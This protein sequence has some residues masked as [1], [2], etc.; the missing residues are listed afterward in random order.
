[1]NPVEYKPAR[2]GWIREVL[3]GTVAGIVSG[4]ALDALAAAAHRLF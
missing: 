4:L 2:R 3:V 1:M